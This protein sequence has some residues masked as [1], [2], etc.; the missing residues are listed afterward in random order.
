M[1][2]SDRFTQRELESLITISVVSHG[3]AAEVDRLLASLFE[4]RPDGSMQIILTDNLGE[5]IPQQYES[6][7][8]GLEI[9]RNSQPQ[10]LARNHNAAFRLA[11]GRYFCLLNPDVVFVEQV[12]AP[13]LRSL[14]R[15]EAQ[16]VAP[17]VVDS[18]GVLQDSFRKLPVPLELLYR[19]LQASLPAAEV[20]ASSQTISVEWLAG[21]F[22]LMKREVFEQVG[23][24]NEEYHLYFE[25]V[26]FCT[27]AR[28][29]GLSM[30][31]DTRLRI[32]HD[33][34]RASRKDLR[35]MLWH[36]SSAIRFFTSRVY[37]QARK[38]GRAEVDS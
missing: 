17:L 32:Q 20:P 16:I 15:P 35:Y 1:R 29:L 28:L 9:V 33:A 26:E 10:G 2:P 8:P 4:Y 34:S 36:L 21:I 19:G 38:L 7:W 18:Q 22:L 23:Y 6:R 11:R 3:N 24:L 25:D 13:L 31:V 5:E 30:L 12:F 27:R 37:R 14:D